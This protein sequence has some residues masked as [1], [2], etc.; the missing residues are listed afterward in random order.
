MPLPG[1][2]HG[3]RSLAGYSPWGCKESMTKRLTLSLLSKSLQIPASAWT[4]KWTV[5]IKLQVAGLVHPALQRRHR[6]AEAIAKTSWTSYLQLMSVLPY[7]FL[8]PPPSE[9]DAQALGLPQPSLTQ[10]L[11]AS[12]QCFTLELLTTPQIYFTVP[13]MVTTMV[14]YPWN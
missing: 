4:S 14:S 5:W 10:I 12:S 7:F 3:Q 11:M 2:F 8:L 9:S 1:K 13:A 6:L